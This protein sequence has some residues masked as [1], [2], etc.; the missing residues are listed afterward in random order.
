MA[1]LKNP[2]HERFAQEL[3]KGK[4]QAEAY[5]AAGYAASEPNASRLT[6]HDKVQAR[7]AELK[8]RVSDRTVEYT[9]VTRA[10]ILLELKKLAMAP[11]GA[12]FVSAKEKRCALVDYAKMEGWFIER[13]EF[14]EPG[15][16]ERLADDEVDKQILERLQQ[17]GLTK[18]PRSLNS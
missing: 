13:H 2:K 15:A 5:E 11:L 4:S 7:V 6:R 8:Q 16:F 14:G 18:A 1:V 17:V 10:D 3:A 9:A 12:E